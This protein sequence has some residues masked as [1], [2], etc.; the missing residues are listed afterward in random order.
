MIFAP[1]FCMNMPK[2]TKN[3]KDSFIKELDNR[4]S[5]LETGKEKGFI[6]DEVK[7]RARQSLSAHDFVGEF[8]ATTKKSFKE[9]KEGNTISAKNVHELL[10]KLKH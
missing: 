4:T 6:W 10:Q 1:N 9:I 5:E 3:K 7:Q 8:N 2:H